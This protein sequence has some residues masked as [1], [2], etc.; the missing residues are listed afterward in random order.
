[1]HR[2]SACSFFPRSVAIGRLRISGRKRFAGT[3]PARRKCRLAQLTEPSATYAN[4]PLEF[5]A[6][7]NNCTVAGE[8][9]ARNLRDSENHARELREK[10]ETRV[11]HA[12][13]ARGP[14]ALCA[15]DGSAQRA[16]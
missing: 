9:Q 4:R 1:M 13:G 14:D 5:D 15:S 3:D 10:T 12:Q 2:R 11:R 16:S 8:A 6:M 7:R